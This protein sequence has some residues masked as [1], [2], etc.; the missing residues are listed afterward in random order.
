MH[1]Y[2]STWSI[3]YIFSCEDVLL[4]VLLAKKNICEEDGSPIWMWHSAKESS[5]IFHW[6]LVDSCLIG[7]NTL[8][9]GAPSEGHCS[10]LIV[11]FAITQDGVPGVS[12]PEEA[13]NQRDQDPT[14]S[15]SMFSCLQRCRTQEFQSCTWALFVLEHLQD[16]WHRWDLI[17]SYPSILAYFRLLKGSPPSKISH[18]KYKHHTTKHHVQ[19]VKV[20]HL[21]FD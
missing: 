1:L 15:P 4:L 7:I 18:A 10:V 13:M 3:Y 19:M 11:T 9:V 5:C 20:C 12:I 16:S 14:A 8:N 21:S 2:H 17:V 6:L